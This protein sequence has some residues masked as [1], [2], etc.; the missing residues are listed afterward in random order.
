MTPFYT[1]SEDSLLK[2]K[3]K[4]FHENGKRSEI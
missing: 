4:D 3:S 1:H 2:I